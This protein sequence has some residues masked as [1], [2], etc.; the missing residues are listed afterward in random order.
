MS[1]IHPNRS[2][3]EAQPYLRQTLEIVSDKWATSVIYVLS[4]G[5]KRYSELQSDIGGVSRR[6]LT[7]TLRNL[8][9]DGIV[10]RTE[11]EE[12]PPRVEYSLTSLGVSLVEPLKGICQWA[13]A[14]FDA[15]EASRKEADNLDENSESE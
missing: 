7:R 6:M 13:M 12:Q 2:I 5:K 8:E 10:Q 3:L 9:R 11:Y 15:V 14:N 1:D 4:L